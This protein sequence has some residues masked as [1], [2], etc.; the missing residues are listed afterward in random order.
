MPPVPR[1]VK[2]VGVF[3]GRVEKPAVLGFVQMIAAEE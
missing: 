1:N 2:G 3:S